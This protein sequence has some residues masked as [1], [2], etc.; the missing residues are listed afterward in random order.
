[1]TQILAVIYSTVTIYLMLAK[2]NC[3]FLIT[4]T[5]KF[6][7]FFLRDGTRYCI[8]SARVVRLTCHVPTKHRSDQRERQDHKQADTRHCQLQRQIG[9]N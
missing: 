9:Q 4:N 2:D 1:M 7:P 5:T 8:D 6:L 3:Q